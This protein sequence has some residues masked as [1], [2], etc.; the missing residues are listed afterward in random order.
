LLTQADSASPAIS[1]ATTPAPRN[2]RNTL[3]IPVPPFSSFSPALLR[4]I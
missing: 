2:L 3:V 1:A 4:L